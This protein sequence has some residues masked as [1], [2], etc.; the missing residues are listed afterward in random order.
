MGKLEK[1][2][3]AVGLGLVIAMSSISLAKWQTLNEEI[4]KLHN[5]SNAIQEILKSNEKSNSD[6]SERIDKINEKISAM[7]ES[8]SYIEQ[9]H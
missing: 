9:S 6:L 4:Y 7:A 3:Y 2:F 8:I 5:E 1:F